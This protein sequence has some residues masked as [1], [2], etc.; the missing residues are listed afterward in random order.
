MVMNLLS[1]ILCL[2]VALPGASGD[3]EGTSIEKARKAL[4]PL[5]KEFDAAR[6]LWV[7]SRAKLHCERQGR[8]DFA[9]AAVMG[10]SVGDRVLGVA[11]AVE[12]ADLHQ[13]RHGLLGAELF[14]QL[15]V[16]RREITRLHHHCW[17]TQ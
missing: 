17:I 1:M 10:E 3:G 2:F 14:A 5:D 15:G 6:D 9:L 8:R 13:R 7:R 16:K 11:H 4:E 12:E